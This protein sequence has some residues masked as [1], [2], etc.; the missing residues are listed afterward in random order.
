M[1]KHIST[2]IYIYTRVRKGLTQTQTPI[3]DTNNNNSNHR[4]V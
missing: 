2:I 4:S 3:H 1:N